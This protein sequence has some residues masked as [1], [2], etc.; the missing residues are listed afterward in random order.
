MIICSNFLKMSY[1]QYVEGLTSTGVGEGGSREIHK[2][3]IPWLRVDQQLFQGPPPAS[4][5]LRNP[6][7]SSPKLRSSLSQILDPPGNCQ[8]NLKSS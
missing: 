8:R 1:D 4:R 6:G 3:H 7:I 2:A 5:Y